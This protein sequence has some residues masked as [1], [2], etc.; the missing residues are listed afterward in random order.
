MQLNM[1]NT[2][3]RGDKTVLICS[4]DRE[5]DV[6]YAIKWFEGFRETYRY[7]PNERD[8]K[9]IWNQPGFSIVVQN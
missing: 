2:V 9:M 6:L 4:Y 1:P 3:R 8:A 7:M 5:G